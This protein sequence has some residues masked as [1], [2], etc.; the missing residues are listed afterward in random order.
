M[1]KFS[2]AHVVREKYPRV[3]RERLD[4]RRRPGDVDIDYLE[5][6]IKPAAMRVLERFVV[7]EKQLSV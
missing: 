3:P 2:S 6:Q 7:N 4:F 1:F 5:N